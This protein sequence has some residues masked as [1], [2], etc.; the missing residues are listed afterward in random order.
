M[1]RGLK[2]KAGVVSEV[3]FTLTRDAYKKLRNTR[4]AWRVI[5]TFLTELKLNPRDYRP[6]FEDQY[7]NRV[8]HGQMT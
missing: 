6:F 4:H 8:R 7:I 3:E 5:S 1:D 2:T